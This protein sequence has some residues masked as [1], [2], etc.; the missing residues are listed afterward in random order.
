MRTRRQ[1]AGGLEHGGGLAEDEL[2]RLLGR[3]GSARAKSGTMAA[4]AM[5]RGHDGGG[6]LGG[7][8]AA[9]RHAAEGA[10]EADEG[11][12]LGAGIALGGALLAAAGPAAHGV[13]LVDL[14]HGD[15]RR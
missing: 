7:A 13:V 3:G 4:R 14:G 9:E 11:P 5:T 12:A 1:S 8:L 6:F 15:L 2:A 10:D